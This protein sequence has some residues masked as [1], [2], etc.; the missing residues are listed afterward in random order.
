M[1]MWI[2]QRFPPVECRQ[3]VVTDSIPYVPVFV[4]MRPEVVSSGGATTTVDVPDCRGYSQRAAGGQAVC[5]FTR[6]GVP[7]DC[8]GNYV[9][10]QVDD[11]GVK[12]G[13]FIVWMRSAGLPT[14]RKTWGRVDVALK[15][16]STLR[17]HFADLFHVRE[18]TG[19]KSFMLTTGSALGGKNVFLGVGYIVL[20][21]FC[22][23]FG[24][25]CLWHIMRK[26]RPLGDLAFLAP[27]GRD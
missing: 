24:L 11:F 5:N 25:G 19:A 20:G 9:P 18:Y 15:A 2:Y 13:H 8:S 7:F 23:I 1:N 27:M 12:S 14:F 16:G 21:C 22:I 10:V 3:V 4:A 17:V 26:P 6:L